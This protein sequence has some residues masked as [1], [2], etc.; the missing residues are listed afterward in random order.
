[1]CQNLAIKLDRDT[2][3]YANLQDACHQNKRL[4]A[5]VNTDYIEVLVT[6]LAACRLSHTPVLELA[7]YLW[8]KSVASIYMHISIVIE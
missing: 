8:A 1:M 3:I 4:G 7:Q 2:E 6:C 5:I